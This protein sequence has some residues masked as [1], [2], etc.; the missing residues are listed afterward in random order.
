MQIMVDGLLTNY[1]VFGPKNK[2]CLLILHGWLRSIDEWI[3]VAKKLS[4][5]FRVILLD[6]PGFGLSVKPKR[7]FNI[8]EYSRF[9]ESFLKKFQVDRCVLM[10]HSFGGRIGI[11]LASEDSLISKLVLVDSAGIE[12][13]SLKTR[14]EISIARLVSKYLLKHLPKK[15]A[16]KMRSF[17]GSADYNEAGYMRDIFK[18]VVREDLTKHFSKIKSPTYILWGDKDP[19][20]NVSQTKIFKN[21]IPNSTVRVVWGAGHNPHIEKPNEFMAIIEEIL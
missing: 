15:Y 20:L 14:I 19:V 11:L 8:R 4:Y 6:L 9:V 3:P 10:G 13:K 1:E 2:N 18:K 17:F 7:S 5:K 16:Y 12:R 21:E